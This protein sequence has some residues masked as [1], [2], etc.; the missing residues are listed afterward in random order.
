MLSRAKSVKR[1]EKSK[2]KSENRRKSFCTLAV[3]SQ[4][5]S[6]VLPLHHYCRTLSF[7]SKKTRFTTDLVDRVLKGDRVLRYV[8]VCFTKSREHTPFRF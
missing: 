4:Y 2:I 7:P 1:S 8:R 5:C 3:T 6:A